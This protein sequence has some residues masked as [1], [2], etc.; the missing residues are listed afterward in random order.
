MICQNVR[1]EFEFN[2]Y[3]GILLI[4][5]LLAVLIFYIKTEINVEFCVTPGWAGTGGKCIW[6][7]DKFGNP[8]KKA[9]LIG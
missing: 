2:I 8:V 6:I 7:N 3:Y 1:I 4:S 9:I 5:F